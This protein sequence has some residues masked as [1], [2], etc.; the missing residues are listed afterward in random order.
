MPELPEA[1]VVTRGLKKY[2]LGA[3]VERIEVL[4][5][6]ILSKECDMS[7]SWYDKALI[8]EIRRHGKQILLKLAKDDQT[9]Y[10][11]FRLGM[12][13]QLLRCDA[14]VSTGEHT[15]AI[16]S[17]M[18]RPF[19]IHY[20]DPRRFGK[21]SLASSMQLFQKGIDPLE[22]NAQGFI[23]ALTPRKGRIKAALMNQTILAGIGN[24]YA[25]EI[26]FEARIHPHQRADRLSSGRLRELLICI[27]KMLRLGIQKGGATIRDFRSLDGIPGRFQD[28][29]KDT[30]A[31][32]CSPVETPASHLRS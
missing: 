18:N 2:C 23:K 9:A 19:R 31:C 10:M 20:R 28:Y 13:G 7:P 5:P 22:L 32:V 1:E 25:N 21:I 15:H 29:L 12:T 30:I 17:F 8:Q 11:G 27:K 14:G 3:K 26:L 16:V 4:E 24:I 6:K